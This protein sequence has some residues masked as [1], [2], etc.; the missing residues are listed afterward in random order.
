M[1]YISSRQGD[2][3]RIL[4][5]RQ[6]SYGAIDS[7]DRYSQAQP[8]E[9]E[10]QREREALEYITA[11]ATEHMIDVLHPTDAAMEHSIDNGNDRHIRDDHSESESGQDAEEEAWLESIK[12]ASAAQVKMPQNG[13]FVMNVG[14]LRDGA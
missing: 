8:D 6:T 1:T 11:D 10:L 14:Q 13:T 5:S 4:D 9:E 3:D 2:L 12:S 7:N